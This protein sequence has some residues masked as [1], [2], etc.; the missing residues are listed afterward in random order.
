MEALKRYNPDCRLVYSSTD[1]VYDGESPPYKA[2]TL[3]PKPESIYG[4]TKL[5]FEE[6]VLSLKNGVILRLS[7][8]LGP[9]FVYR[10]AGTKFLQWLLESY[11]KKDTV[12]LRYDEIRSF[13]LV[14]D[15]IDIINNLLM[16]TS[17]ALRSCSISQN[18]GGETGANT[19]VDIFDASTSRVL[20]LE[21]LSDCQDLILLLLLQKRWTVKLL[22]PPLHPT[23]MR[24]FQR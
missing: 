17:T 13:V 7:N 21:D 23:P 3:L 18:N 16:R 6:H 11:K 20:V 8:M 2:N 12:G 1:L 19:T 5:S 24:Q 14:N 15:V 4:L 10:N 9:P 22:L